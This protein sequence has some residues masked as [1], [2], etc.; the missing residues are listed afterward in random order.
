MSGSTGQK[1]ISLPPSNSGNGSREKGDLTMHQEVFDD[2]LGLTRLT[3]DEALLGPQI[4]FGALEGQHRGQDWEP[5]AESRRMLATKGKLESE[6]LRLKAEL[7]IAQ[8]IQKT[9]LPGQCELA[10]IPALD[11]ATFMEPVEEV[12]GDYYDVLLDG[13]RVKIGIGDVTGHGVESGALVLMVQ[14]AA[15]TL[16]ENGERDPLTFLDVLNRVIYKNNIRTKS[17]KHLSLA[18]VDYCNGRI[19]LA[20]QHEDV[21]IFRTTGE[22]ERIDTLDLGFPVGLEADIRPFLARCDLSFT[23]GDVLL[24]HTD[25][26]TEAVN[27]EGQM[28]G[29]D[30]LCACAHAHRLQSAECISRLI[31]EDL[32]SHIGGHIVFDDITLMILKHR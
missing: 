15:R 20:G 24:L 30:R 23:A 31:I 22:V 2:C 8:R 10:G 17:D 19:T 11:I 14:S 25:G 27:G 16:M 12:G 18:F 26:I 32:K 3:D 5:D 1:A 13:D 28:Y 9:V 21:L 29:L 7:E 4:R 6:N